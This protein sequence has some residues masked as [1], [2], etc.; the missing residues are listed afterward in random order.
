MQGVKIMR[1]SI[2]RY[3]CLFLL[4]CSLE[5]ASRAYAGTIDFEDFASHGI[6]PMGN[7]PGSAIPIAAELSNQYQ[8]SDGVVFNSTANF[9]AV[10]G[11][12]TPSTGI[13]GATSGGL[14]SYDEPIFFKFFVP[15]TSTLGVTK[16]V[17]IS[18]DTIGTSFTSGTLT[19]FD[20]NGKQVATQT[21]ADVGGETWDL[22]FA[23]GIHS[24]EYTF[25]DNSQSQFGSGTGIALDNLIFDTPTAAATSVTP[26]PSAALAGGFI[27]MFAMFVQWRQRRAATN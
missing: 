15:G 5:C 6:T 2:L 18:A 10:V 14:L 3:I 23:G 20:I 27:G 8:A 9:V 16:E 1:P 24:V 19:A 25:T 13:G 11:G 22:K 17:Q 21:L 26:L 7:S 4:A 12:A